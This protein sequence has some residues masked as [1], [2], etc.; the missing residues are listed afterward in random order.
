MLIN[1]NL[2]SAAMA[3]NYYVD[4]VFDFRLY[5]LYIYQLRILECNLKHVKGSIWCIILQKKT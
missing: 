2:F 5:D 3:M 4:V 1:S